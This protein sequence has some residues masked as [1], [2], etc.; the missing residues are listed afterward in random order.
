MTSFLLDCSFFYTKAA[1]LG[2]L[3]GLLVQLVRCRADLWRA[4]RSASPMAA[5]GQAAGQPHWLWGDWAAAQRGR[6]ANWLFWAAGMARLFQTFFLESLIRERLPL[7]YAVGTSVLDHLVGF[8]LVAKLLGFSRY[9]L[10]EL[11]SAWPM[12]FVVWYSC[13]NSHERWLF[14]TALFCLA[15]KDV[16]LRRLLKMALPTAAVC[17][18]SVVCG[19]LLGWIPTLVEFDTQRQR[20]SFGYEWYNYLGVLLLTMGM[21]YLCLRQIGRLRWWDVL[22]L[23]GLGAFSQFGPDS[24]AATV[25]LLLLA[26][27]SLLVRLWP[28][29]LRPLA[30]RVALSTMPVLLFAI[31]FTAVAC[32]ESQSVWVVLLNRAL[33]GRIELGA[34]ALAQI[35]VG[36]LG[37]HPPDWMLVDNAYLYYWIVSGPIVALLMLGLLCALLWNL[38]KTRHTT[39]AVCL[40]VLLLH[41][42]MERHLASAAVNITL[43]LMPGVLYWGSAQPGFGP[44]DQPEPIKGE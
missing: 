11:C 14:W 39:E 29:L 30:V 18:L 42:M 28:G 32:W 20:N 6:W 12:F 10:G 5:L 34:Q 38:L 4:L 44:A 25:C 9:T 31:S 41:A 7:L 2:L 23:L 17:T 43:L 24:R 16:D 40:L 13:Q 22:V 27:G 35:P 15:A 19:S 3:A 37:T 8:C 26:A 1:L 21:M 33:S 36:I